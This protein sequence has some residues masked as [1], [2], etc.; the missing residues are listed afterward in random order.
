M[1]KKFYFL[2]G[3]LFISL[4]ALAFVYGEDLFGVNNL[5]NPNWILPT[6]IY[7]ENN[8]EA[9]L[10]SAY[11]VEETGSLEEVPT[12]FGGLIQARWSIGLETTSLPSKAICPLTLVGGENMPGLTLLIPMG[13]TIRKIYFV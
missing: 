12:L 9:P 1:I 3:L 8:P 5:G 7:M 13:V 11:V 4:L 6:A 2:F 10:G